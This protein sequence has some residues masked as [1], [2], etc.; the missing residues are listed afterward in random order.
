MLYIILLYLLHS[1]AELCFSPVGLS[2]MTR[3]STGSIVGLMMGTWFL[4]TA[5]GNFLAAQIAQTTKGVDPEQVLVVYTWIGWG[6][7]A[8]GLVAIPVSWLVARLMRLDIIGIDGAGH[9]LAGESALGEP[10][11]AGTRTAG[12]VR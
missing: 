12:E 5:A 6:M 3:L 2:S 9:G 11:A 8:I 1:T 4:G 10:A 7:V